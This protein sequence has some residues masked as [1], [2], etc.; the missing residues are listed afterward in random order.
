[1]VILNNKIIFMSEIRGVDNNLMRVVPID[2][3]E[4]IRKDNLPE[5]SEAYDLSKRNAAKKEEEK[6]PKKKGIDLWT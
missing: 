6:E 3:K 1:M 5:N 4:G 2:K